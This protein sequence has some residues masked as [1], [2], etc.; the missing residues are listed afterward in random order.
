MR[1]QVAVCSQT[2]EPT[3]VR[4]A[5]KARINHL[6]GRGCHRDRSAAVVTSN[7]GSV[8]FDSE[9]VDGDVI[10][11]SGARITGAG[12]NPTA[13]TPDG[14]L[15]CSRK[16]GPVWKRAE[17]IGPVFIYKWTIYSARSHNW[18]KR[19][20]GPYTLALQGKK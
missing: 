17:S 3:L 12:P 20:T 9:L 2:D 16:Q 1:Q 19:I 18:A 6:G 8:L 14:V 4:P 7:F 11:E 5:K 10:F 15:Y 13:E